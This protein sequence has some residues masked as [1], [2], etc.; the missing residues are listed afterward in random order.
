MNCLLQDDVVEIVDSLPLDGFWEHFSGKRVLL[1][2]GRGFLGR[3]FA[4]VFVDLNERVF[5]PNGMA[6]AELVVLDNLITAGSYGADDTRRLPNVAFVA[7]DI[8]KPFVP[9]RP[10]DFILHAAG[11][12]SPYWYR[13]HPV[14]TYRVAVQGTENALGIARRNPDC[15]LLYFS[16][17]EIYGDPDMANVPTREGYKGHVACLGP[18]ATYDSSKR[19]AETIVEIY[20]QQFGVQASIVRPFNF[21][22]PGMQATDYRVLPNFASRWVR[23]EPLRVYGTGQQTRTFCY[24]TDGIK[25][26]LKVLL[27]GRV[28]EPYNIGNPAPEI[29]MRDLALK[30]GE[31]TSV[32]VEFETVEHPGDYPADEPQRR[33]PDITKAHH[34][35]GYY[36][37]VS[38]DDGLRRFFSWAGEA[39]RTKDAA[40]E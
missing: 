27:R 5:R 38:L 28:G 9:E 20:C 37:G 10:V 3:Y 25:G 19:M 8:I 2:G 17:S 16:S 6:P 13:R 22:G 21:Y 26:C 24:V 30:V 18:R 7:H 40:A 14:E 29:N 11:I 15:R 36:P 39:F 4:E 32:K 35:V 34:D 12:A 1:T 31:I 33:C 23:G